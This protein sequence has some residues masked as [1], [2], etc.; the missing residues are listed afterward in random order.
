MHTG[1]IKRD[2]HQRRVDPGATRPETG[3]RSLA[4]PGPGAIEACAPIAGSR[5][6]RPRCATLPPTGP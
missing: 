6:C 2:R 4:R 5:P 3:S 1:P